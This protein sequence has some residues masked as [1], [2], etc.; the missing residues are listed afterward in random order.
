M[1]AVASRRSAKRAE[2]PVTGDYVPR[3]WARAVH[4]GLDSHR[5][6][7]VIAHRRAGK[8]VAMVAQLVRDL[9]R[10]ALPNPQGAFIAPTAAQARK[11]AWPYFYRMLRNLPGVEFREHLLEIGL[12]NGGRIILASGEQYDRLRGL[13]LDVAV[14]DEMADCPEAL[15]GQVLRPALLDRKGSLYCIGTVKGRGPFWQLYEHARKTPAEWFSALLLPNDTNVID[16]DEL[17]ALRAE[18][19]EDDFRQEMLCDPDAAV[20]GSYYGSELRRA[21]DEGRVCRVPYDEGLSV[22]VGMDL[23]IAD[24]TAIWFAQILRSG[25]VRLIE[26]REYVNTGFVQILR[27]LRALPYQY[28]EFIGPHDLAVREFTSGQSRYDAA[29]E[30]GVHFTVAPRLPVIDGIESVRRALSRCWFDSERCATGLGALP[31]YRSEFNETRRVLSR[32]PVH[33]WTSHAA[34][35]LRYLITGT[36]GGQ[37]P[38]LFQRAAPIDYDG[39]HRERY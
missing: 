16:P 23:G 34:D 20:R 32:N 28:G 8:T 1:T 27:E 24:A 31:L 14:V 9:F 15:I 35:A 38:G 39:A 25:E 36:Q 7:V 3:A 4:Q 6:G 18:M 10:C 22:T 13:Y 19:S 12:P 5:N 30:V 26:Y 2:L 17:A 33:D 21:H 37:Q 11:V 29:A